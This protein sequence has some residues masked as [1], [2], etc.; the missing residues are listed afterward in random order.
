MKDLATCAVACFGGILL[1]FPGEAAASLIVNGGFEAPV[2]TP[3]FQTLTGNQLTGWTI[4]SG[5]IDLINGYWPAF[6][7]KQSID[8]A[9]ST[10]NGG[11]LEQTFATTIGESYLL[12]FNY[13]NNTDVSSASANVLVFGNLASPLLNQNIVHSGS[14]NGSLAAM[15]Y[16]RFS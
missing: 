13:T 12:T 11:S 16:S 3:P 2:A 9:G 15:N 6:E 7:G 1:V 8:L 5:S 10:R 14:S 4:I